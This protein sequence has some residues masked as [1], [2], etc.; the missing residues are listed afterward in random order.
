MNRADGSAPDEQPGPLVRFARFAWHELEA[1]VLTPIRAFRLRY[2]PLLMVYFAYG[3]LGLTAIASGFWVKQSLTMTP[4]DLAS[5]GVWLSLP[6][7][8]KM[9]FGEMV[10][11][12]PLFGSQR[13]IYVVLGAGLIALGLLMLAGASSGRL[14]FATPFAAIGL[15]SPFQSNVFQARSSVTPRFRAK[16]AIP[17]SAR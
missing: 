4:S 7:A 5:L 17:G 14:T 16:V 13:R 2:L 10:D 8:M 12:V 6:W 3:A 1:A 9:V 15:R 11:S